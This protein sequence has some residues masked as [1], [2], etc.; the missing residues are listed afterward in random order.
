MY[1]R[2]SDDWSHVWFATLS[3]IAVALIKTAPKC[4]TSELRPCCK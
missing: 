4:V 1:P 2:L 3:A